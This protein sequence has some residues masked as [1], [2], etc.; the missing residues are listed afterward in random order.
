MCKIPREERFCKFCT[1][2]ETEEHFFISCHKYKDI[3]KTFFQSYGLA[4]YNN[5]VVHIF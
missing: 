2:V 5:T 4:V 1:E 3:R